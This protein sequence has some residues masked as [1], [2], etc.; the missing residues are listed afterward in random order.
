MTTAPTEW[1][2]ELDKTRPGNSWRVVIYSEP[3]KAKV[4]V[5]SGLSEKGAKL[6]AAAPDMRDLLRD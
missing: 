2:A 1:R 3:D 4:M 6:I 5:A